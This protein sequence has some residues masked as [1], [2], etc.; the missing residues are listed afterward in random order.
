VPVAA[1]VLELLAHH[2]ER[3]GP[4]DDGALVQWPW[5]RR[6]AGPM[7]SNAWAYE[8]RKAA[9]SAGL[10][11]VRF[12]ALRHHA[13]SKLIASGLSVV[14]VARFLGHDHAATMLR[15]YG[16]RGRTITTGS[17]PLWR[18]RGLL[19]PMCV[20]RTWRKA[21]EQAQR[22]VGSSRASAGP[23]CRDDAVFQSVRARW[24]EEVSVPRPSHTSARNEPTSA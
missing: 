8:M 13:A 21:S 22:S 5:S 11:R 20:P 18:P 14:A 1:Q 4:G 15:V 9:A 24:P 16:H 7:S 17:A 19:C 10:A 6:S 23:L 12:H 3:Y 2:L